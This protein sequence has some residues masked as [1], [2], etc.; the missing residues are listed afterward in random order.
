[1]V[2]ALRL[3]FYISVLAATMPSLVVAQADKPPFGLIVEVVD[4]A[5]GTIAG[6][7]VTVAGADRR[8]A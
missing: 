6:A 1:M 7:R 4:S 2:D 8:T 3:S 5:G